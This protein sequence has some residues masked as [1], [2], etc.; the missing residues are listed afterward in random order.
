M[1]ANR[2]LR[3]ICAIR[4]SILAILLWAGPA[5][6]QVGAGALTGKVIDTSSK[7]PVADAVVTATSPNL[8]GEQIVVTDAAG[9]YRIQELPPG[10]Y[11]IRIDKETYKPYNR[12]GIELRADTTLQV[13]IEVLPE[14]LKEEIVVVAEPPSVDIGSTQQGMN[15]NEDFTRRVP[16]APPTAKG[17]DS[18]SFESAA[19][20]APGAQYDLYGTSFNGSTSPENQYVIDGL[21]VN[22]PAF[23]VNGTPLSVEFIQE[24]NVITGGYMP[25][26]GRTTGGY[27]NVVT[28]SGSNQFHGSVFGHWAPGFLVGPHKKFL[29]QGTSIQTDKSLAYQYDA[30]FDIGGPILRDKIWFYG[31]FMFYSTKWNL[32]R[33]LYRRLMG[34]NS[35][36]NVVPRTDDDGLELVERI[37]GTTHTYAARN[38]G[39]Q[40]IGKLDWAVSRNDKLSL[41]VFGVPVF[42]GGDGEYPILPQQGQ[43]MIGNIDPSQQNLNGTYN[44]LALKLDSF[45]ND[46]VLKYTRAF[47]NRETLFDASLGWHYESGGRRPVDDSEVGSGQRLSGTPS[48]LWTDLGAHSITEF[49]KI[50]NPSVCDP[51]GPNGALPCPV[52]TSYQTGGPD[53]IQT[54]TMNRYQGRLMLTRLFRGAGHHV[55]KGGVDLE[56][57]SYEPTIVYSGHRRLQDYGSAGGTSNVFLETRQFGFLTGPDQAVIPNSMPWD[58][59]SVTLGGFA[60]DNWNVL[61][62]FSLNLGLRY[63]VQV[64]YNDNGDIGM[65]VPNQWSPRLGAIYDVSG[66]GRS[67]IYAHAARYYE[68]VPLDVAQRTL[69]SEPYMVSALICDAH[70][71][72][73]PSC[74]DDNNRL[75]IAAAVTGSPTDVNS[76]WLMLGG[77]P[78]VVDPDLE[79][80]SSD[81][82]LIGGEYEVFPRG[83]LGLSYMHRQLHRVIEDLS[84]D[85]A[86]TYF[87]GNPGY[88]LAKDWPAAR[89]VYDAVTLYL[90]KTWRNGWL[91]TGSYTLSWLRGN[92]EGLFRSTTTQLDPNMNTIFD[93]PDLLTNADGPLPGD[94]RH[95]IKIF[96]AK[97]VKLPGPNAITG[98]VG[99]RAHSGGP[100]NY[101]GAH[102]I[103]ALDEVFLLPRGS[104]ER[105]PWNFTVDPHVGYA[106]GITE[107]T[108]AEFT[109]D[110]FN[111]FNFQAATKVDERYT[112]SAVAPIRGGSKADLAGCKGGAGSCN[113][114]HTA[115]PIGTPIDPSEVNP[116]FGKPVQYQDPLTVRL[117]A[118]VTF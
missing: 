68:S 1:N 77:S 48:I 70:N 117:G 98:G 89:R 31:G 10:E 44:A 19:V 58:V 39:L 57:A 50:P 108:T 60:Q 105:L 71:A 6:A 80:Q 14:A 22:D 23:G 113:A 72:R 37:P 93:L 49:E 43:P 55:V 109:I 42:S 33:S 21:S 30:G 36:G 25:E 38:V 92:Y 52:G 83:R 18:R 115:N 16:V 3:R 86:N 66:D 81:E 97:E 82:F 17:G 74:R 106:L 46:T 102:P 111:V 104:G 29:R 13:N 118:R 101:L 87:I 110:V 65:V 62:Q 34:V 78:V 53:N 47:D 64:I 12:P 41:G 9:A 107:D 11:T 85:N 8:Q 35:N 67:K 7:V 24:T 20:A 94:Y 15:I 116:D 103:Y 96:G 51:Q 63:D 84:R 79:P 99:F 73:D 32:K 5:A 91:A 40:Y 56:Q 54:F 61:D 75:P 28:Q 100:T 4:L 112:G 59:N 76:K 88:G 69:S 114:I 2:N 90:D 26:Y 45:S 27:L 95:Q